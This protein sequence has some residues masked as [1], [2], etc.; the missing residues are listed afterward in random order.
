MVKLGA[1]M[2]RRA[3]GVPDKLVVHTTNE[4]EGSFQ[5][6]SDHINSHMK[7]MELLNLVTDLIK[8]RKKLPQKIKDTE[9]IDV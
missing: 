8:Q 5:S 3:L 6:V 7:K 1:D 4:Y 9:V 2:E